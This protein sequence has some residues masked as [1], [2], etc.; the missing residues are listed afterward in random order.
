M[1]V[2]PEGWP[3]IAIAFAVLA[4]LAWF[5]IWPA[6]VVWL[7]IAFLLFAIPLPDHYYVQLTMPL[8][9]LASLVSAHVLSFIP[10]LTLGEY[11]KRPLS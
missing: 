3:F 4:V 5:R 9:R 11:L 6:V 2:A 8:R 7:P 10:D 1:R